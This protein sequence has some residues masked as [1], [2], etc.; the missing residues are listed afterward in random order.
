MDVERFWRGPPGPAQHLLRLKGGS[1]GLLTSQECG[2]MY[3]RVRVLEHGNPRCRRLLPGSNNINSDTVRVTFL[4][5]SVR[6]LQDS[7]KC[8]RPRVEE[9]DREDSWGADRGG[10]LPAATQEQGACSAGPPTVR[11]DMS[12]AKLR[13][14]CHEREEHRDGAP[15]AG[16]R[17]TPGRVPTFRTEHAC[18][19]MT[20]GALM[21]HDRS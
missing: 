6:L 11:S 9:G 2:R 7:K 3:T 4:R 16:N 15:A 14:R 12:F 20:H 21:S 13:R 5:R 8:H 18:P 10:Q 17:P 19:T 1:L